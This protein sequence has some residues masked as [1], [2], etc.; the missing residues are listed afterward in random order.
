MSLQTL[1]IEEDGFG[2]AQLFAD[3]DDER[4]ARRAAK[5]VR[6]LCQRKTRCWGE[7]L[8]NLGINGVRCYVQ[9]QITVTKIK[10][11]FA[12]ARLILESQNKASAE[13]DVYQKA[14]CREL[15][16]VQAAAFW[17]SMPKSRKNI[18]KCYSEVDHV[19]RR[20]NPRYDIGV[21]KQLFPVTHFPPYK[22]IGRTVYLYPREEEEQE[23]DDD[24]IGDDDG[25]DSEDGEVAGER[26]VEE[27]E[28]KST[29]VHID[30]L[31]RQD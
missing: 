30:R 13:L 7:V 16:T 6:E 25:E 8:I 20:G 15:S 17:S 28:E 27:E 31:H 4:I 23:F 14:L 9:K 3:D 18:S 24:E 21:P 11:H 5:V 10:W 1:A 12:A 29:R 26:C 19:M 22:F 2:L